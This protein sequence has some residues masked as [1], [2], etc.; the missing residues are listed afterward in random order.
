MSNWKD[1]IIGTSRNIPI[2]WDVTK[3]STFI[4][5]GPTGSGKT[6]IEF[7]IVSQ[8]LEY[9]DIHCIDI[10]KVEWL[11]CEHPN[12]HVYT[13]IDQANA[14]FD[15]LLSKEYNKPQLVVIEDLYELIYQNNTIQ[16]KLLNLI[17]KFNIYLCISCR[18]Y[19]NDKITNDILSKEILR[20]ELQDQNTINRAEGTGHLY[21][22]ATNPITIKAQTINIKEMSEK[23]QIIY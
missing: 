7:N 19:E 22:K 2:F 13:T 20:L 14:C 17:D 3:Y 11:N 4:M 23:L 21:F 1:I 9:Y 18:K 8:A 5:N 10:L 12:I 6:A 15:N 16:E